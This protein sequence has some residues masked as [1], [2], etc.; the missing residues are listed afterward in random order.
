MKRGARRHGRNAR[1]SQEF[2]VLVVVMWGWALR[3]GGRG[4]FPGEAGTYD[5]HEPP[6]G[7]R[8]KV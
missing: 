3:W 5:L 6:A 8:W 1:G 7:P 2:T 4:L